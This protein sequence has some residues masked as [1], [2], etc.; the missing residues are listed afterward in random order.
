MFKLDISGQPCS[1]GRFVFSLKNAKTK[2]LL[3]QLDMLG[4]TNGWR[5]AREVVLRVPQSK[6]FTLDDVLHRSSGFDFGLAKTTI[7]V[8]F[9]NR[10]VHLRQLRGTSEKWSV[11]LPLQKFP[12]SSSGIVADF[13]G[14]APHSASKRSFFSSIS[15]RQVNANDARSS[16]KGRC[17]S[18]RDRNFDCFCDE[19]CKRSGDCCLDYLAQCREAPC[20]KSCK[21]KAE[22]KKQDACRFRC[23]EAWIPEARCTCEAHRCKA[24]PSMCCPDFARSCRPATS[25]PTRLSCP[26]HFKLVGKKAM[27]AR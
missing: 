22:K 18:W 12:I 27:C 1:K 13:D 19:G 16:C 24:C 2:Q 23:G 10:S 11:W 5:A 14:R 7:E 15:F 26:R 8:N 21:K 6:T 9:R 20:D 17:G 3:F 25:A 4:N